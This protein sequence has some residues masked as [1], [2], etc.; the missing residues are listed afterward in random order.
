MDK[1]LVSAQPHSILETTGC[2]RIDLAFEKVE[3]ILRRANALGAAL[4]GVTRNGDSRH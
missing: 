1:G 4:V 3:T 2:T